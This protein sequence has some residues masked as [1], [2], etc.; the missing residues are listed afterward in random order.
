MLTK[1]QC[2]LLSFFIIRKSKKRSTSMTNEEYY[3]KKYYE[4][5]IVTDTI[6]TSYFE[7]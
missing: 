4:I 5:A 1:R 7:Y 3:W 2:K 6:Y